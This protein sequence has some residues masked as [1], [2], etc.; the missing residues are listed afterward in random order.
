[1]CCTKR[2]VSGAGGAG[3]GLFRRG[4]G[5]SGVAGCRC[6]VGMCRRTFWMVSLLL[7]SLSEAFSGKSFSVEEGMQRT[8][9]GPGVIYEVLFARIR[10]VG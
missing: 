3:L 6:V 9:A 5:G 8:K 1:M 2:R 10:S 4:T 7:S